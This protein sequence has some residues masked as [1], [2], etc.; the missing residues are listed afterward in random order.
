MKKHLAAF[1]FAR[2]NADFPEI[3][4]ND[5]TRVERFSDHDA[6]IGF[7]SFDESTT[8]QTETK[9]GQNPKK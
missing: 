4:R 9:A 1:G 3:Y 5:A 2:L 7:F 8:P 6:A